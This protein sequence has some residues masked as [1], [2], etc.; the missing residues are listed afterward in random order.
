MI[1][2]QNLVKAEQLVEDAV[3]AHFLVSRIFV[4]FPREVDPIQVDSV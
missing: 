3:H 2:H 1:N 4:A